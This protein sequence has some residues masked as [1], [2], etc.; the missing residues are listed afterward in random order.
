MVTTPLRSATVHA[1]P[2][3]TELLSCFP[4]TRELAHFARM[5]A[6]AGSF[7]KTK[8]VPVSICTNAPEC[9]PNV[10][11]EFGVTMTGASFPAVTLTGFDDELS[12]TRSESLP[13]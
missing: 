11:Q 1:A 3:R 5:R 4:T 13:V 2:E 12:T 6:I 10:Y 9:P 8:Q 7:P